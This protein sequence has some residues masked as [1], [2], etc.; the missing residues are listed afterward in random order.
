MRNRVVTSVVLR[1]ILLS[2]SSRSRPKTVP[3]REACIEV[4]SDVSRRMSDI[5]EF[6]ASRSSTQS[7]GRHA[8]VLP[9]FSEFPSFFFRRI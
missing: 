7:G 3:I 8:E 4:S 5:A 9:S 1:S 6:T 2:M